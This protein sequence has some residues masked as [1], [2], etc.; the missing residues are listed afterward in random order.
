MRQDGV[1]DV[2]A[3]RSL[4]LQE[5]KELIDPRLRFCAS[6][7]ENLNLLSPHGLGKLHK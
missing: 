7:N 4:V 1:L 2:G 3:A 6:I 5:V